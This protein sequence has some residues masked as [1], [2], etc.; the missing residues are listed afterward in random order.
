MYR[1]CY[2]GE[3]HFYHISIAPLIPNGI[4]DFCLVK[5]RTLVQK[6]PPDH[7]SITQQS[8]YNQFCE[9]L[10]LKHWICQTGLSINIFIYMSD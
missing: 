7:F 3:S 6:S 2:F 10:D 8:L 1:K 9:H 5:L 4:N